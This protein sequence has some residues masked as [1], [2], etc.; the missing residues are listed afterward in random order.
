MR[1]ARHRARAAAMQGL[2]EWLVAAGDPRLIG[3]EIETGNHW[4]KIDQTYFQALWQGVFE[5]VSAL[6]EAL[7]PH[8]DRAWE[9]VS[10]VE[11]AILLVGAFELQHRPDIP[12][13]VAINEGVELAKTFGGTDGHKFI[14]GVLD[15]LSL[16][17]RSA[18]RA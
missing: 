9:E 3:R 12:Y 15:Q 14:N 5:H 4:S 11:R 18:E 13:R 10:P 17:A 1:S 16:A 7:Q 6:Q 2:Y 8:L